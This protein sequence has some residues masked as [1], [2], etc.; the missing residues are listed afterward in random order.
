MSLNAWRLRS[1][2]DERLWADLLRQDFPNYLFTLPDEST[3]GDEEYSLE[4]IEIPSPLIYRDLLLAL[5]ESQGYLIAP[6]TNDDRID[7]YWFYLDNRRI[8]RLLTLHNVARATSNFNDMMFVT[9]LIGDLFT[10]QDIMVEKGADTL[11]QL[12]RTTGKDVTISKEGLGLWDELDIPDVDE[13][14]EQEPDMYIA[15]PTIQELIDAPAL[16]YLATSQ[17]FYQEIALLKTPRGYTIVAVIE[18]GHD[19]SFQYTTSTKLDYV[20]ALITAITNF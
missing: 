6:E 16:T 10:F 19:H 2:S 20:D 3:I 12:L 15:P 11:S 13:D 1:S 4:E 9:K 14:E 8:P 5:E 17:Q 18:S 7:C